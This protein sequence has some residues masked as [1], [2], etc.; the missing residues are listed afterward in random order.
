MILSILPTDTVMEDIMI[1]IGDFHIMV[2]I[3]VPTGT[4]TGMVTMMAG[5]QEGIIHITLIEIMT[6][7]TAHQEHPTAQIDMLH[8]HLQEKQV[9]Q[10]IQD[11]EADQQV[12]HHRVL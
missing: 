4:D 2:P 12:L 8:Q 7:D 6:M 9:V 1:I 3:M 10:M 11:T 5:I